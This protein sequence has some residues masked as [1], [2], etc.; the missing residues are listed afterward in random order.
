LR[1][2]PPSIWLVPL[3]PSFAKLKVAI[4]DASE[5]RG[6]LAGRESKDGTVRVFGIAYRNLAADGGCL[7]ARP[8]IAMPATLPGKR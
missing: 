2:R 8:R 5:E 7:H 1:F 4:P 6:P 3:E